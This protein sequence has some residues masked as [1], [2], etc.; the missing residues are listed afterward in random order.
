MESTKGLRY[1]RRNDIRY[2]TDTS[3]I[4]TL[5]GPTPIQR[6]AFELIGHPIPL[7]LK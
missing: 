6:R 5:A 2:G 4:L 3:T 1:E 7:T